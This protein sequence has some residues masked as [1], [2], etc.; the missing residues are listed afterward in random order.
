MSEHAGDLVTITA[1]YDAGDAV[2]HIEVRINIAQVGLDDIAA[3]I[4]VLYA[5]TPRADPGLAA[6]RVLP[7]PQINGSYPPKT[8]DQKNNSR[9]F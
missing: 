8:P 5:P 3:L 9:W 1:A 6:T 7:A 2:D 4:R